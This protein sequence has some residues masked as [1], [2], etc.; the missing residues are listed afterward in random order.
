MPSHPLMILLNTALFVVLYLSV[1]VAPI[2]GS[3]YLFYFL[4]TLPMRR[5]ERA[6]LFLDL[7][8]VGLKAGR[9]PEVTIAAAL[10]SRDRALGVRFHLLAAHLAEG[11]Q[12]GEALDA[13]PRMLPPQLCAMMRLAN[14][15]GMW[16]KCCLPAANC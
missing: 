4:L 15:L 6:R 8:E 3:L 16:P 14:V 1:A 10:G 12:L 7:V 5:A 11:R 9:S 13:V 2:A